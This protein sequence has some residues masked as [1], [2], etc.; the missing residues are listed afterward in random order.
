M[1]VFT[2]ELVEV[3]SPAGLD[4]INRAMLST[5]GRYTDQALVN[6]D[7]SAS[8]TS[9]ASLTNGATQVVSTGSSEALFTAN[10]KSLL[11]V[12]A[13]ADS[14]L[15]EVI[16]IMHPTT[17]LHASQLLTAGNIRA[18]PD[19]GVR[20]G[21]IWGIPV[22]TSTGAICSGS[23]TERVVAVINPAGVIVAD[24]GEIEVSANDRV[25]IHMDNAT[26]QSAA[27]PTATSVVSLFQTG[28]TAVKF[29]RRLNFERSTTTAVSYMR[30]NF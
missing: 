27:T 3:G 11:Q 28:S 23:P 20:G 26:T 9:P 4:N 16:I 5:V 22:L 29:V 19:L 6:P 15:Q 8:G 7:I 2:K 21:S 25:A 18:F 12:H 17:A 14:D 1:V 10:L 24:N 13:S 30:V